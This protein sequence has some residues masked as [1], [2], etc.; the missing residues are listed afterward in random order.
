[1]VKKRKK[2]KRTAKNP[3][4]DHVMEAHKGRA[5]HSKHIQLLQNFLTSEFTIPF[6][7]IPAYLKLNES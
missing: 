7:F 3:C 2:K 1:M 6:Y 5:Q 4:G